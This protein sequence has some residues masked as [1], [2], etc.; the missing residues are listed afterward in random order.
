MDRNQVT[1]ILLILLILTV[2]FQFFKTT[3][4][5]PKKEPTTKTAAPKATEPASLS[6]DTPAND[7]LMQAKNRAAYGS[8]A[9]A[10][11]GEAKDIT[12]ENQDIRVTLST[13][14]GRV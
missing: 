5:P 8:F 3:P 14:G 4:L 11:T 10:A 6:A 13:K 9:T 12:L 1:G 2:Y 7:S